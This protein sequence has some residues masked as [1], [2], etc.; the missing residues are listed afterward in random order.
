MSSVVADQVDA[1]AFKRLYPALYY[2]KFIEQSVRPDGRPLGRARDTSISVDVVTT[3]DSSAL[4]KVGNTTALAGIKCEVMVPTD[5][6]PDQGQ[7]TVQVEMAPLCSH[8][9]RPGRSSD[10]AQVLSER[11]ASLLSSGGLV[12]L[13]QLCIDPG[14]VAWMAY[15]DIYVLDADGSVYDACLLAMTAALCQL[16]LRRVAL[17]DQGAAVAAADGGEAPLCALQLRCLPVS[18]TCGLYGGRTVVDLTAEEEA[19]VESVVSA[20]VDREGNILAF[21]KLGG[22]AASVPTMLECI[23][24]AKLRSEEV[25]PLLRKVLPG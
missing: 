10:K 2:K 9:T 5:E 15:V 14:K 7:I 1:E 23:E 3:A 6:S 8:E 18:L 21:Q 4:V 20:T 12:D 24:A 11:L 22:G 17:D 16:R 25:E 13:K 19:V